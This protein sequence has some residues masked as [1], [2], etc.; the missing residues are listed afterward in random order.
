MRQ[1][2]PPMT[3][4]SPI[5]D[6]LV[7]RCTCSRPSS[8]R[9]CVRSRY[10]LIPELAKEICQCACHHSNEDLT[11]PDS[12]TPAS[13]NR[14]TVL[15]QR[16][17]ARIAIRE[18]KG[19]ATTDAVAPIEKTV[20]KLFPLPLKTVPNEQRDASGYRW[21]ATETGIEFSTSNTWIVA[22]NFGEVEGRRAAIAAV[23]TQ[24]TI[25]VPDNG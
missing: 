20:E 9:E 23:L 11:M 1:M 7:R 10:P 2:T 25:T 15:I 24:P 6:T 3:P 19:Y 14:E 22:V 5:T 21:R 13:P 12:P 17:A 18:W 8:A 16:E 4:D